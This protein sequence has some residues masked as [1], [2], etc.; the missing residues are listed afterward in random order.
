MPD[1]NYANV[2]LLLDC[3]GGSGSTSFID[4]S[5]APL[6][7]TAVAGA[8]VSAAVSKYGSGSA[9][10]PGAGSCLSVPNTVATQPDATGDFTVEFWFRYTS[11]TTG[12]TGVMGTDD[13]TL[14]WNK[15]SG[16]NQGWDIRITAGGTF[17]S[18]S[19]QHS[20][21][22][23]GLD[24]D[25]TASPLVAGTFYHVAFTR[26]GTTL[27]LFLDG[28]L[29]GSRTQTGTYTTN[30]TGAMLIGRSG[31]YE[32]L[33][34]HIDDVRITKGVARYTADFTPPAIAH[35]YPL[36]GGTATAAL[37]APMAV[38]T[39]TGGRGAALTAPSPQLIG[40]GG[41]KGSALAPMGSVLSGGHDS[42]GENAAFLSAPMQVLTASAGANADLLAPKPLLVITGAFIPIGA[43]ALKAPN[44]VVTASGVV[45]VRG[46]AS[47][48]P[49]MASLIG[50]SG[51]VAAV[52]V[53]GKP[54]VSSASTIGGIGRITL[55]APLFELTATASARGHG[56]ALLAAPS[57][58]LGR[59]AQAWLIAPGYQ[60]TA[61][62]TA[63]VAVTYEAYA[64]NLKHQN[65]ESP[66]ELTHYTNY[67][68]DKIVRYQNSYFGV[69]ATGL[70]LL[71]GPTDF[72][73][74]TPQK[75]AWSFKTCM[76]DFE[77]PNLKTVNWAYFGGRMGPAA[78]VSIHYGDTGEQSYAYTTPRG[79]SAQNY[80]QAFGRGIKSRY[81]ALE[82]E[83]DG[84]LS[85]DSLLFDIAKMARRV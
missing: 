80:R 31:R 74:P 24:I 5:P 16:N 76:T 26:Q 54:L 20:S 63:T 1:S 51:A 19:C 44:P 60:L 13:T 62:G 12:V 2:T 32:D 65:A 25:R 84:V 21:G 75:V 37:Q 83:G 64:L 46:N 42:F 8:N 43:A 66:D 49:G 28:V 61:I 39:A 35:E 33:I 11:F 71:E 9:N 47:V 27:R 3:D 79:V 69:N 45:P 7:V 29:G 55:T 23:G 78:T 81:Y 57:P 6:S 72:A 41:A 73:E 22:A 70:Y 48:S 38:V 58:E 10:I 14:I 68:F 53:T 85:L 36:T 18:S 59:T 17:L 77:T 15:N 30:T 67:P 50:Y 40:Y 56:S 82:V 52:A 34:G 4:R